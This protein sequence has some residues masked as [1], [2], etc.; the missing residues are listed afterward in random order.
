MYIKREIEELLAKCLKQFPAIIITGSRQAGK[1]TLLSTFLKHYS[2]VSLDDPLKRQLAKD[3]P[4]LFLN[5]N[6]TPLIIDEIQYA[7][8]LLSYIKIRID[9]D[10]Q[11]YGQYV[12]TGSQVFPMMKDVS[13]SL[14]GRIGVLNLYPLNWNELR[15]LPKWKKAFTHENTLCDALLRGFYPELYSEPD[16]LAEA[17]LA[18]FFATYIERDVR[19]IRGSL[20]LSRFQTF[21]Q[22]L[23]TRA[24]KLLNLQE[25][26]KET[27]ITHS[28]A[29]DWL[30]ILE[31]TYIVYLLKP[32]HNNLSKRLIKSPKIYFVDTGLL[33]YLLGIDSSSQIFKAG[34]DL[35]ENMIVIEAIKHFA[36]SFKRTQ[37]FFYRT[38]QG[39]EV[40]LIIK[41]G[42]KTYAFEIKFK[43]NITKKTTESLVKFGK[44]HPEA[45][46]SVLSLQPESFQITPTIQS[47]H[48]SK[49]T[50]LE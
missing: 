28:T 23:A 36:Y 14:A 50:E 19:N 49:V 27:G 20:N 22:L 26:A 10:R 34:G 43:R 17:W 44:D 45:I 12:L 9:Q 39:V 31:S 3:E 41:R 29:K 48:W 35:F 32:Y 47:Q 6:P 24:G 37:F 5:S 7:P 11:N 46:L 4:E 18:S 21:V 16:A 15:A 40:D 2:Y 30:T 8:E 25:I 42:D 38:K 13:E 1:S 33:C